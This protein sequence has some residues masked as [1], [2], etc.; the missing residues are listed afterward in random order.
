M[1]EES[2]QLI[3]NKLDQVAMKIGVTVEQIWPWL[4]RQ[5]YVDSLAS[6]ALLLVLIPLT[7]W[8]AYYM[9][10]HWRPSDDKIY[11]IYRSDHEFPWTLGVSILCT[12]TFINIVVFCFSFTK[13]FNPEYHALMKLLDMVK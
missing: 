8:M 1:N 13:I 5:Q 12:A 4:I 3:L 7:G 2:I 6:I 10:I 9:S 11:S